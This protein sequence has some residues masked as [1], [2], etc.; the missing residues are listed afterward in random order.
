MF[1]YKQLDELLGR[2]GRYSFKRNGLLSECCTFKIGGAA[3]Y[4]IY[5]DYADALTELVAFLCDNEIKHT[6]FGNGSNVLFPDDG[7][8]GAVIF[9]RHINNI[10]TDGETLYVSSGASLTAAA[11]SA[12]KA[13]LSGLEFSYGIPGSCG[14]AV[15]M[16]AGAFGGQISDITA[17]GSYYDPSAR[18]IIKIDGEAHLFKYRRSIFTDTDLV[19]LSSSFKLKQSDPAAIKEHM[20][21][22]MKHRTDNQPL[23]YP[24]AGSVFKRYPGYFTSKLIEEAGLKGRQVGGAQVSPKHAGFIINLGG[25]TASDVI[26]LI[27]IIKETVYKKNGIQI[28][29]E[30]KFI[31]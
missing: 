4:I 14:G 15:Y 22:N 12:Y 5:P 27:D 29:C 8:H 2:D 28:E 6:V 16:N 23:E 11:V 26:R 7:Y 1:K 30:I 13:G 21:I 9:T 18:K 3:D 19:I 20:Y 10:I 25:A 31:N 24:S 17:G